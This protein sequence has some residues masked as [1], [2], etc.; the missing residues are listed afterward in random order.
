MKLMENCN[1]SGVGR[2]TLIA[3]LC[4]TTIL[5]M[6]V[7]AKTCTT[8]DWIQGKSNAYI[9]SG[10]TPASTDKIEVTLSFADTSSTYGILCAR[11]STTSKDSF[12]MFLFSQK[13]RIDHGNGAASQVTSTFTPAV[14]TKYVVVADGNT[15]EFLVDGE[16]Y[17]TMHD[18]SFSPGS[19]MIFFASW[20]AGSSPGNYATGVKLYGVRIWNASGALVCDFV[21]ATDGTKYGL[22]N[23]M[24]K[25]FHSSAGS[26]EIDTYGTSASPE[27]YTFV[28]WQGGDADNPT[29]WNTAGNWS[30]GVPSANDTVVIPSGV[31][32]MPVLSASTP[33]LGEITVA[34][35]LTMT[36]WTTCLNAATVTISS[37]GNLTCGAAA[38]NEAWLSRVWVACSNLTI[39][40]GGKIDVDK[41]G[42]AG[43]PK[44]SS[45]YQ[46]GFG[47]GG[48]YMSGSGDNIYSCGASHGGH[49][50]RMI[51][52]NYKLPIIMPYDN[53][54][55]P[56]LP[57]SSGVASR[58]TPG[59]NGGGAVKIEATG[60]VVVNGSI[61]AS[62]ENSSSFGGSNSGTSFPKTFSTGLQ[63]NHDQAGSGG[64]IFVECRTFSGSGTL[65]ANGGGGGWG[66]S[67]VPS[68]PAGGGMIAIH[69][70][71]EAERSVS[72]AGMKI[73][74][75]AGKRSRYL[76]NTATG[77]TE[78]YLTTHV[79]DKF[80]DH[81]VN[82][83]LGTVHFTDD[84]IAQQLAGKTLVGTVFGITN[85]VHEGDWNFTGGRVRFGEDGVKVR[86]NGDLVFSGSDSRL[87]VGGGIATNWDTLAVIYAGTNVNQMTVTGDL[88][89]GGVS[90][91]DIRA[92]ATG[93][94]KF[95]SLV[96]VGG[97][98]TIST[99]CFV[100]SWSDCLNLGSPHFEV[101]SL[102]VQTGGVFSAFGRG[103]RG[104][105]TTYTTYYGNASRGK[106]PG[107]SSNSCV[108]GS[109]G[110]KGGNAYGG[111][112]GPTYD[113]EMRPYQAGTGGSNYGNQWSVS[114]A[115]GG[116]VYVTATNGTIRVNGKIDASGRHGN[117]FS[118]G[119]GGGGSGGTILLESRR[120][121]GGE[122]GQLI[123]KGGDTTPQST[124]HSG[125]GGGGRIAVWCG[126]PWN[127]NLRPSRIVKSET[128]LS[129]E[130]V[131]ESFAYAGTYSVAPG[132]PTGSNIREQNYGTDGT[133]WFCYVREKMGAMMIF[134]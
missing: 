24:D 3:V 7:K 87:E 65:T 68:H 99:N 67:S 118:S 59:K 47:P 80:D 130:E 131:A 28:E 33:M 77:V 119:Y 36:N 125:A 133:V 13:L 17:A 66:F 117:E 9:K 62:G 45:K 60:A 100:Y 127:A 12:T 110:G 42:Y 128:P 27:T 52:G 101:G 106:G 40:S 111:A 8:L 123:A 19:V 46:K 6:A 82:A 72:V 26:A 103:G 53:P 63:D 81:G 22:F 94:E 129:G 97:T 15:R 84:C 75:D 25:T 61:Q 96:K 112:S 126:E 74:A 86:V 37:G 1:V 114:G 43:L 2:L 21:P 132:T 23:R 69:Y 44:D 38:T 107:S 89:L 57:G 93:L 10:Y 83:G 14:N 73:S 48:S 95:G 16:S 91:L 5:P 78:H 116:L 20:T 11:G 124:V 92:A 41:K 85:F 64:S 104:S 98:M 32:N 121:F 54:R 90:R 115:G 39:A 56:V 55:A 122:T 18:E 35:T 71:P 134:R 31:A 109:H 4:A 58:W 88:M 30:D 105:Y 108:G 34:G 102:D 76:K 51:N 79:D 120:F 29:D 50:G 70:D 49:G 113:D